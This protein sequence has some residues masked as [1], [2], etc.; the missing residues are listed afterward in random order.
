MPAHHQGRQ[1]HGNNFD[2]MTAWMT[3]VVEELTE[4]PDSEEAKR[5]YTTWVRREGRFLVKRPARPP[6]K[7]K[8]AVD[9]ETNDDHQQ[10]MKQWVHRNFDNLNNP[11]HATQNCPSFPAIF[12]SLPDQLG[13]T[14]CVGLFIQAPL[15]WVIAANFGHCEQ[16]NYCCRL[17]VHLDPKTLGNHR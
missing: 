13:K 14:G 5:D 8:P 9:E 3:S 11:G 15:G 6:K 1:Y 16:L 17:K 7:D 12:I 4:A 10:R 2:K